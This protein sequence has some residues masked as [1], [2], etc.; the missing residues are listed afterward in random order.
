MNEA[1]LDAS[2]IKFTKGEFEEAVDLLKEAVKT[3][4]DCH[5]FYYRLVCYLYELGLIREALSN[6]ETALHLNRSEHWLMFEISPKLK[7]IKEI[8]D[9]IELHNV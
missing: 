4:P 7:F 6:L 3:D 5:Q 1:W 2:Y 9:L 8:T